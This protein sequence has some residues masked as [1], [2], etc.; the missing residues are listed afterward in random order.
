MQSFTLPQYFGSNL[1]HDVFIH[2][3]QSSAN[4]EKG[5]VVLSH[6]VVSFLLEGTK[7]VFLSNKNISIKP[8]QF[9]ILKSGHCLMTERTSSQKSYRSILL[10]FNDNALQNFCK[11][12]DIQ[13]QEP[14][15]PRPLLTFKSDDFIANFVQSLSLFNNNNQ[16]LNKL[17]FEELLLYCVDKYGSAI[18][19]FCIA[20]HAPFHNRLTNVVENALHQKFCVEEMAFLCNM[21]MSTFKREFFKYY[22]TTPQR[23]LLNQRLQKAASLLKG[24]HKRPSDIFVEVGFENLSSFT[25]SFK[26]KFGVTPKKYQNNKD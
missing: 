10:F 6:H 26:K 12:Y 11:K 25:Q 5:K 23:W 13:T 18:A 7:T 17:K 20:H 22:K 24:E 16:A 8:Q 4:T 21:S 3:Y 1:E 15:S 14:T 9:L 2:Q 19:D